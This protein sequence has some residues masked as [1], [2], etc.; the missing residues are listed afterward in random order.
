[1]RGKSDSWPVFFAQ[2][3]RLSKGGAKG[4]GSGCLVVVPANF[5]GL[6]TE[7]DRLE[8]TVPRDPETDPLPQ[9]LQPPRDVAKVRALTGL[10]AHPPV[11]MRQGCPFAG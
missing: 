5:A 2:C 3:W 7:R 6:T 10:P 1:M 4:L 9:I 8:T 11:S